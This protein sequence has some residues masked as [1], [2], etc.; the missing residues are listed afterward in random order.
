MWRIRA[1][2]AAYR[3]MSLKEILNDLKLTP[4]LVYLLLLRELL[5]CF[6]GVRALFHNL[7][8]YYRNKK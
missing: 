1:C 4:E 2:L 3:E 7:V 6:L 8:W 5:L